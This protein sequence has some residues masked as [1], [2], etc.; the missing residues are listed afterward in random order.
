MSAGS[1]LFTN[2][3]RTSL[4]N[5]TFDVDTDAFKMALFTS[6][7]DI[8]AATASYPASNEVAQANGYLTGGVSV[9][10]I[11]TGTTAVK[12][13][14]ST[15]P[16]W[17]ASGGS[18]VARW[19]A[20]YEVSGNVLCY[21]LLDSASADVTATDGNTLTVATHANGVFTLS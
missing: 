16:I 10:L 18:L 1:W 17:T 20:L 19:G 14:V 5:G 4:I 12:C 7:S 15:D 13:D 6:S 3:G 11:L 2:T 21:A 8:G 9:D